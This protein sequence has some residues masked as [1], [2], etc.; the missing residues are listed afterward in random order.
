[1]VDDGDVIGVHSWTHKY[2]YIYKSVSDFMCDFDTLR[3]Y[4]RQ[5]TGVEPE[6]CR[7]P[8]G[9]NNTVSDLYSEHIM[10][11]IVP[12]VT[13]M[14]IKPYDWNVDSGDAVTHVPTKD[15][16]VQ[17]VL[18]QSSRHSVAVILFHD[19]DQ[20]ASTIAALPEIIT[21]L[22]EMGYTFGTLSQEGPTV[23]FKAS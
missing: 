7:F 2:S 12:I 16:I 21:G 11:K 23:E 5:T 17:T 20:H 6:V 13:G 8:G 15:Q 3:D 19:A 1:M 22:R 10:S 18:S 9:T 4:I 14:G